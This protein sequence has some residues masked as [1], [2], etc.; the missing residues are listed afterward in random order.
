MRYGVFIFMRLMV[1]AFAVLAIP[2]TAFT[3]DFTVNSALNNQPGFTTANA[4]YQGDGH[5]HQ[6]LG[7]GHYRGD[8]HDHQDLGNGH[9]RGDGHDHG[10]AD[11]GHYRDYRHDYHE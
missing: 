11:N 7:N 1:I 10:S 2:A 6:A 8:G 4:H 9:Y 5:G 3:A